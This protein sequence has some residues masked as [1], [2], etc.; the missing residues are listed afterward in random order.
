[1]VGNTWKEDKEVTMRGIAVEQAEDFC[2]LESHVT[3]HWKV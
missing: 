2:Y 1:M 3:W